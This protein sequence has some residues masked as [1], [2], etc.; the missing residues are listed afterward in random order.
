MPTTLDR[1]VEL[2]RGASGHAEARALLN[3]EDEVYLAAVLGC[4][5]GVMRHPLR[6][7]RGGGDPDVFFPAPRQLKQR[8]DEVTRA[9]RWQRI[10]PPYSA[11]VGAIEADTQ[12]LTDEWIFSR[13]ETF[14]TPLI[15]TL[16]RQGAPARVARNM[17]LPI[18]YTDGPPPYVACARFPTGAAAI[19]AFERVA[20]EQGAF[21]PRA[22]VRWSVGDAPGP[23]G[24]FG[25]FASLTLVL[26]RD[27]E[28]ARLWAQDLAGD[29]PVEVS[30][31]VSSSR[32]EVTLSGEL[33][34]RIGCASSSTGDLSMPALALAV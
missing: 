18:V 34:D 11:G 31:M 15:G 22:H 23:F 32:G 7:L 13:G 4:T 17:E 1:A 5:M 3:V 14:A 24:V 12:A 10:A 29:V 27:R 26:P 19:G 2:L 20:V 25:R 21:Q 30:G 8:M 33:I 9:L 16:V 6:G 28:G